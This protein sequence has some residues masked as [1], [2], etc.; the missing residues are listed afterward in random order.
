MRLR[1]LGISLL[2]LLVLAVSFAGGCAT[3]TGQPHMNAALTELQAARQEL[4][5]AVSDKGG[6]RVNA[7]RLVD[8]AISETQA[9][10]DFARSH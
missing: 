2:F 10:I 3:A 6:H 1:A 9:G 4:E 5:A 7:I 8:D